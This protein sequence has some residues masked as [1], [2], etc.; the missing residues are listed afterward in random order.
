ME[1]QQKK[2]KETHVFRSVTVWEPGTGGQ[3]V[4]TQAWAQHTRQ[5]TRETT[6]RDVEM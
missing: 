5:P 4:E 2:K 3:D 1:E 6:E